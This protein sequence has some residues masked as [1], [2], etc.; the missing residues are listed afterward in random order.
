MKKNEKI[1]KIK[2]PSL[3]NTIKEIFN[4]MV[5]GIKQLKSEIPDIKEKLKNP[6]KTQYELGVFHLQKGNLNDAKFRFWITLKFD[7]KHLGAWYRLGW[8]Y[9]LQGKTDKAK[10]ALSKALV[11]KPDLKEAKFLINVMEHPEDIDEIPISIVKEDADR[12][13]DIYETVF[14]EQMEYQGHEI[15]ANEVISNEG[16]IE[17]ERNIHSVLDLGCGTGL[18]GICLRRYANQITGIDVSPKMLKY[19]DTVRGKKVNLKKEAE[20]K[21]DKE[22]ENETKPKEYQDKEEKEI[23]FKVYDKLIEG[24]IV[25]FLKNNEQKFD[26]IT[27]AYTFNFFSNLSNLISLCGKSLKENGL[28]VFTV[29]ACEDADYKFSQEVGMF[30]HSDKHIRKAA[31]D[32]DIINAD[33]AKLYEGCVG[34]MVYSLRKKSH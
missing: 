10:N 26:V 20:K 34:G 16:L 30:I 12:W 23:S 33:E 17:S 1:K 32:F 7:E 14:L 8:A 2:L 24:E 28:L 6:V 3:K 19:A 21:T 27:A 5:K 11:I 9:F 25:A 22:K 18:C 4:D 15:T 31:K 13:A 29:E